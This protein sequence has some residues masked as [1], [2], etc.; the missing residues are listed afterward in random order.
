MKPYINT[1]VIGNGRM[2]VTQGPGGEIHRLFWP[3]IDISQ[4][5]HES[6]AA[7][8]SPVLGE[9]AVRIDDTCNWSHEQ[10]YIPDSCI[11]RT[12]STALNGKMTVSTLDFVAVDKDI[13]IRFF[14]VKNCSA[15]PMPAVLL[16]YN[17]MHIDQ[18]HLF[19][20]AAFDNELDIMFHYRRGKWFA[21]AGS[22]APFSYQCGGTGHDILSH[23]LNGSDSGMAP[24]SCQSWDMGVI[25]PGKTKALAVYL[26]AGANKQ[27]VSNNIFFARKHG[28]DSFLKET[29]QFWET[30]LTQGYKPD[31]TDENVQKLFKNSIMVCKLLMNSDTGGIIAAPEF[32]ETFSRCGGYGYCWPRDGF[33]IAHAM[34]RA[35]YP[36][37]ARAFYRWA[38]ANQDPAG[39][40]PQRK[41]T[42][43]SLAPVWGDQIDETGTVIW[44]I[45]QYYK[46]T[47]DIKYLEEMWPT[48]SKAAV[49]LINS[50][51]TENGL[52]GLSYDLWEER[53]GEHMYSAAAVYAG[54]K[55]AGQIAKVLFE[56]EKAIEWLEASMSLKNKILDYFWH[57]DK[58]RFIRTGWIK[59]S[60]EEFLRRREAGMPVKEFTRPKGYKYYLIFEDSAPDASLLGLTVPFGLISPNDSRMKSTVDNLVDT[61]TNN[62]V[63]GIG[64]YCYDCY[65]GGNPWVI[66]T[67]WLGLFEGVSGQWDRALSRL[68]WAVDNQTS[69]GLLP[70]QVDRETG[71][72]AWAVPLAWSHAMFLLLTVMLSESR[73]L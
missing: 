55:G 4:H 21:V 29:K 36:Q 11:L 69:L 27:E 5:I 39:G 43:G 71:E 64:R 34:L 19:N 24:A 12:K 67:L 40:W 35:G 63:G 28:W 66:T 7:L 42:D 72:P 47:W 13:L 70:E 61:L 14:E 23:R 68:K 15:A 53:F 41:Y 8:S 54:L 73:K 59:V 18:S 46:E 38:A 48:V 26:T 16:Y 22:K 9:R 33:Y 49:F 30:Y 6:W 1:A 25:E 31:S 37:Y 17:S 56:Q 62:I 44:G 45:C 3:S 51:D 50:L 58:D 20:T 65:I 60:R 57:T 2:L 52:P 10:E 32:D